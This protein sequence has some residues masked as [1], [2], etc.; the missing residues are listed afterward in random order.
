M[1]CLLALLLFGLGSTWAQIITSGQC[2]TPPVVENFDL[3]AF[4]GEWREVARYAHRYTQNTHCNSVIYSPNE[5]P[6]R[7]VWVEH[8]Y[9]VYPGAVMM[10][11]YGVAMHNDEQ[12]ARM[13]ASFSGMPDP[14]GDYWVIDTDYTNF[15]FIWGCFQVSDNIKGEYYW[16]LSRDEDDFSADVQNR[17]NEL[18]EEYLIARHIETTRHDLFYCVNRV[19]PDGNA[20]VEE[21]NVVESK[22][23]EMRSKRVNV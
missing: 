9:I 22:V 6:V 23:A 1:K 8:K 10:S 3:D 13:N 19:E 14:F 18:A 11:S 4:M 16:L 2:P 7:N 17:V 12:G 5:H 21:G 20:K 15:A